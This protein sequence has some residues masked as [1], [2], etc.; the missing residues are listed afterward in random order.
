M[1]FDLVTAGKAGNG[2]VYHGLEYG[3]CQIGKRCTLVDQRL[4]I[5]LCEYSAPCCDGIDGIEV[6][7]G[8]VQSVS[9]GV[10]QYGHLVNERSG[11]S[12]AGTVHPLLHGGAEEGDLSV[13]TAQLDDAV[14]L[15]DQVLYGYGAG[16]H[17]LFKR[18]LQALSQLK[19]AGSGDDH[20]YL[21][22]PS[23]LKDVLQEFLGFLEDAGHVSLVALI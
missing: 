10:K 3:C 12:C 20:L 18:K 7:C 9:V 22:V 6:L 8:F 21:L 19:T 1:S 16:N 2:L 5:R 17:F 13:L 11:A 4:Y 15:R 23:L 14:C